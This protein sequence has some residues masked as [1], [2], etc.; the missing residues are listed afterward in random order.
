MRRSTAKL[1]LLA[2]AIGVVIALVNRPRRTTAPS[3]PLATQKLSTPMTNSNDSNGG[4]PPPAIPR[5]APVQQWVRAKQFILPGAGGSPLVQF[6][7]SNDGAPG[8]WMYD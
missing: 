6:G 1:F 4:L 5:Q 3:F 8:L 7:N 2:A